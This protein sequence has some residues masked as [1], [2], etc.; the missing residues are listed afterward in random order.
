MGTSRYSAYPEL[1]LAVRHNEQQNT[2]GIF[3]PQGH[4]EITETSFMHTTQ[5]EY[6]GNVG[7]LSAGA[8]VILNGGNFEQIVVR[9]GS[10]GTTGPANRTTYFIMGGP[11][12]ML[13]FTPGAHT[14]TNNTAK[15][16][17]CAVNAIGGEYPEFYL[18]GIYR[19]DIALTG[20]DISAQGNPHCYTNGGK[21]NLIA[22]AGYDKIY[23]NITFKIDHSI[24]GEFYGGGINGSN[25]VGGSIDVTIDHSLVAKYCGGPKVGTMVTG[26]TVTTHATGTTFTR[27]YG[28]GN[29]GTS[30]YRWQRQDGNVALPASTANG[31]ANYGYNTFNP[32]NSQLSNNTQ[33]E[34]PDDDPLTPENRGYN[35]LFEFECFVESNG[36]GE[37]PTIRSYMH[38][39]QFGTTSTGNITNN[40]NDCTIKKNFYGG[41]NLGNVSGSVSSTLTDC[42]VNGSVFGGGF[43]GKIEPFRIHDRTKTEFPY[44]DKAGIMH[45]GALYYVKDGVNDRYY[46]WT[47]DHSK[48]S[49]N[50]PT[51]TPTFQGDDGKWYVYTTVPLEGLGAVSE[52]TSLII[53][54]TEGG[55][56]TIGTEG[57]TTTGNVFGGGNESAVDGNTTVTLSGNVNVLG[58]VFGGGNKAVVG[59]S[60][61]VK[62]E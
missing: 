57:D 48:I 40:L 35:A 47:N 4:F 30:Y 59:G 44:I 8:P 11:F 46:T 49:G 15:V 34:G 2:I 51:N 26:K 20:N 14:N 19:P 41:G 61:D 37:N 52:N 58:N 32:L 53:T 42:T 56:S 18:S 3:I 39:A 12:R 9:Y 6:D 25:P 5:F 16:R 55:T 33:Y 43:S 38:W 50:K 29:G 10:S 17:L 13:R 21:F 22:G 62:I 24:I 28:G 60:T 54:T 45:N 7:K 36:L 1:G 31:W 23:G 27:F